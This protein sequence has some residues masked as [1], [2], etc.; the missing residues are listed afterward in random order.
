MNKIGEI[1]FTDGGR[2][3]IL[4]LVGYR[5]RTFVQVVTPVGLY[6][7]SLYKEHIPGGYTIENRRFSTVV[8]NLD[9]NGYFTNYSTVDVTDSIA[10][11]RLFDF[12]YAENRV[13]GVKR[14][15]DEPI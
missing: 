8:L 7:F 14:E 9:S 11:F 15:N 12:D 6:A 1:V 4:A 13:L 10:E 2:V 5:S 3:D